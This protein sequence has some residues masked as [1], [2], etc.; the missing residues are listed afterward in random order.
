MK[1]VRMRRYLDWPESVTAAIQKIFSIL[2]S[3]GLSRIRRAAQYETSTSNTTSA[4][5]RRLHALQ[6]SVTVTLEYFGFSN[7]M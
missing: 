6:L 1:I 7:V 3:A 2:L 5:R 4:G